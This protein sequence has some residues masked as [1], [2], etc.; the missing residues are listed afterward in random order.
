MTLDAGYMRT[1]EF[2]YELPQELIAQTPIFERHASK[3]FVI[4]KD[5]KFIHD[6]FINIT[7]HLTCNDVLVFNNSKV[8]NARFFARKVPTGG[9]F[10]F[11]L[12]KEKDENK[13]HWEALVNP[14][15][16]AKTGDKFILKEG[17]LECKILERFNEGIRLIELTHNG[18]LMDI[19]DAYGH[20]PTPPYIKKEIED[21]K[22]YQTIY[23]QKYGS[24]AAPTAGFHFTDAVFNKLKQ[25]KVNAYF[26]TLHVG[27]GTFRPI[28]AEYISEHRMF[29]EYFEINEDTLAKLNEEKA[30]GKK[31]VAV[32]T[33]TTRALEYCADEKGA[34][35]RKQGWAELFIYP[36]YKFKFVD[37]LITNFHLPK[38]TLLMLICALR[39]REVIKKAYKEAIDKKYRFYSFGDAMLIR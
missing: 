39:G 23:A 38:S 24:I 10:E 18:N 28:K 2:D 8:F 36:G 21:P 6:K 1:S 15:R 33:T 13:K 32:G 16:R 14:G 19:L 25:N 31:I 30:A 26:L 29:P 4:N 20:A 12:I 9:N 5:A 17:V 37:G 3:L 35:C 27:L 11:L 7:D 22:T 34:L